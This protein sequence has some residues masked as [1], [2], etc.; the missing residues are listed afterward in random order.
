MTKGMKTSEF[1]LHLGLQIVMFLNTVGIWD[2]M[3]HKYSAGVQA[4]LFAAYSGS[5][6]LAKFGTNAAPTNNQGVN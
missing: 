6:G 5:R 3:P 2:Y 1:W 4:I